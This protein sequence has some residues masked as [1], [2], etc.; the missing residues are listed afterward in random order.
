[1]SELTPHE[2][3]D[4]PL[5]T[6]VRGY[7]VDQVDELLDRVADR[8]E[9]LEAEVA[10]LQDDLRQAQARADESSA[11]ESTLKRTLVTAQRAAEETVAE[12]RAEA[13][14]ILSDAQ[15]E[16][17]ELLGSSRSESE[18]LRADAAEEHAAARADATRTR[19]DAHREVVDLRRAADDFRTRLRAHLDAHARLLDQAPEPPAT[20]DVT[21]ST[22][23]DPSPSESSTARSTAL[24]ARPDEPDSTPP[25]ISPADDWSD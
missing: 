25:P 8:I 13:A 6:G 12:A 7:R 17:D 14:T 1:M 21:P 5:K 20:L 19:E 18:R 16:A 22:A 23:D 3:A 2:I 9:A 24:F 10:R 11:T 4:Y 15:Q